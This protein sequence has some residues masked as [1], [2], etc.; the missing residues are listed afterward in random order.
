MRAG[1]LLEAQGLSLAGVPVAALVD[2]LRILVCP[3][4][5]MPGRY[6]GEIRTG[7]GELV[8]GSGPHRGLRDAFESAYEQ[9]LR[10]RRAL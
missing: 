1:S 8:Y 6:Y 4:E 2:E 10:Y 7:A 9:L 5:T 3:V